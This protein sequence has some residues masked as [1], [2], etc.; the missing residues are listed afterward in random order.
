MRADLTKAF[1]DNKAMVDDIL[2]MAYFPFIDSLS[3]RHLEQWQREVKAPSERRL[4]SVAVT[5]LTQDITRWTWSARRTS[6]AG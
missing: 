2:T 4:T 3:Y 6:S 5:R 1:H